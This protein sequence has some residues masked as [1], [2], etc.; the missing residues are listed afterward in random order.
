[1][2]RNENGSISEPSPGAH[3]PAMPGWTLLAA[4]ASR[5]LRAPWPDLV[6][7]D[8]SASSLHVAHMV[9]QGRHAVRFD[10]AHRALNPAVAGVGASRGDLSSVLR[11]VVFHLGLRGKSAAASLHGNEVI[12]RRLALPSMRR[13]EILPALALECRKHVPFPIEDAVIRYEIIARAEA[14]A[15]SGF[16]LLVAVAHHRAVN[17]AHEAIE[18][19]GL[20]PVSLTVRPVGLRALLH[21]VEGNTPDEVVAYLDLG[22][23]QSHVMVMRG[24]E[25]RF[26]REFGVGGSDLTDALRSIVVPGQGTL[27]FTGE[28]A[29]QLWRT[30]GIPYGQE[31]MASAGPIPGSAI[32][33]ML[34]PVLERL[35][36]ELLNSF[37]YCNE[38]FLGEAVTKVV[39]L[40]EGLGLRNLPEYLMGILELPVERADLWDRAVSR[41]PRGPGE[42]GLDGKRS[43]LALGL[44]RLD[45]GSI[46]FL[47]P[48]GAGVA[49][50]IAEVVPQRIAIAAAGVLLLSVSLPAEVTVLRERQQ[51]GQLQ[52]TLAELEPRMEALRHFRAAR[53]E[54]T[55]LQDLLAHLSGGQVLWSFVLRDLS[56]R[57]GEEVRL[58]TV[59][60]LD[61][62]PPGNGA[63]AADHVGRRLRISGLLRTRS[64]RPEEVIGGLM[65][66]L[67][68]SP[69]LDHIQ[70]EGCQM[71][72]AGISSFALTAVLAE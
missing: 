29:E 31:E 42:P 34:R 37:D 1:M 7:V 49:H 56:H 44:S 35:V 22:A 53:E 11:D 52:A 64:E 18:Q 65:Q 25:I 54:E 67:A 2:K 63:Q 57:I 51:V 66:S 62:P 27:E 36:R 5:L 61:A 50:R 71:V 43:D 32:A 21:S 26:S 20:R 40:G 6:G 39:L 12:V 72:S 4:R 17:E 15:G 46:N 68:Q 24:E 8:L 9:R 28:E 16:Q 14:P 33:V 45:R 59:E 38:Q 41:A 19:A 69:V 30:H 55:R 60:V 48:A 13:S 3:I 10:V 70:L 47:E 58:T 23:S